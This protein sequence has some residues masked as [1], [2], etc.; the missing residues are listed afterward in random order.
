M[1]KV[2]YL[3]ISVTDRCNLD[4]LY[5]RISEHYNYVKPSEILS[6]EEVL[7]VAKAANKLGIDR[8]RLTGGEPLM[9][10]N[11]PHLVQM[12]SSECELSDLT[13]TTN[14]VFLSQFAHELKNCGLH[15]VNVSLDTLSRTR[16]KEITGKD[17]IDQVLEGIRTAVKVGLTPVKI[18]TVL[19]R[20]VNDDEILEIAK[21]ARKDEIIPRFIEFM[22][23][24]GIKWD[25]L[26]LPISRVRQQLECELSL[27]SGEVI[28]G[29]GP[30]KY[31]KVGDN[32]IGL[33]S[34]ISKKFCAAC[35][36]IRMTSQGELRPCLAIDYQ[37]PLKQTIKG[38]KNKKEIEK[39]LKKLIM[40]AIVEKPAECP[41]DLGTRT[42]SQMS[43]IGG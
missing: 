35:N 14:G 4:C 28:K 31:Y 13:I 40:K 19:M 17:R 20:G 24:G 15:R 12:L 37:I 5:C 36:R 39:Q 23:I 27:H 21:L 41:W 32:V 9:R 6:F 8:I 30:A 1:N 34:P 18:N 43:T 38:R 26:F 7:Q 2:N 16:Y 42:Q 25:D 22:P 29:S 3:R 11:L 10:R 33:I